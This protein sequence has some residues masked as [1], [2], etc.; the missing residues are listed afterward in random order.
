M[1]KIDFNN[2]KDLNLSEKDFNNLTIK[3]LNE[4]MDMLRVKEIENRRVDKSILDEYIFFFKG[5]N[6]FCELFGKE[7]TEKHMVLID[8]NDL[9]QEY[10]VRP[11]SYIPSNSKFIKNE[12][13]SMKKLHGAGSRSGATENIEVGV[14]EVPSRF[15]CLYESKVVQAIFDEKYP[16]FNKFELTFYE[17]REPNAEFYLKTNLK[18]SLYVPY[19]AFINKDINA[20]LKRNEDYLNWYL[21]SSDVY[22]QLLSDEIVQDFIKL[23]K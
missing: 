11:N 14:Y 4:K 9:V 2:Y 20:I 12:V 16:E 17:L 7:L 10:L 21:N 23:L 18:S 5:Y 1:L 15:Q 6:T 13:R 22:N 3:E 19:K 8:R